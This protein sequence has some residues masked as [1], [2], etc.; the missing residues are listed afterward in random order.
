M[1]T[2]EMRLAHRMYERSLRERI[3]ADRLVQ[4]WQEKE[5]RQFAWSLC[6]QVPVVVVS[7]WW[8]VVFVLS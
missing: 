5:N 8:M 7:L 4:V 3:L 6:W 1:N 2:A